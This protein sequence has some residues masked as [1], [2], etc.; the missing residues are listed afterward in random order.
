MLILHL[1]QVHEYCKTKLPPPLLRGH[2]GH[3]DHHLDRLRHPGHPDTSLL[4]H[5]RLRGGH[6]GTE[7]GLH[8]DLAWWRP[9][10]GFII[11]DR[12]QI[13]FIDNRTVTSETMNQTYS[14]SSLDHYYQVVDMIIHYKNDNN[15]FLKIRSFSFWWP[16]WFLCWD[17]PL[18]TLTSG[19]F[20]GKTT[21][22][23]TLVGQSGRKE[24]L[25]EFFFLS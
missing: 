1:L 22:P 19:W 20:S 6:G 18:P 7:A 11:S 25:N 8:H 14:V 17:C 9:K 13:W 15:S 5:C 23:W 12:R 24:R 10:V 4:H 2:H 3:T 16:T 21:K